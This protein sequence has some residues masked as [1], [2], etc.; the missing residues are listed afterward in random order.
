MTKYRNLVA[1]A[2]AALLLAAAFV[3][4]RKAPATP[5]TPSVS[6]VPLEDQ[7][8]QNFVV[9][10]PGP[11]LDPSTEA[12]LRYIKPGGI[13]LYFRNFSSA[14][15]LQA[16]VSQL[17]RV[18]NETT[19]RPYLIMIDEE[20]GGATRLGLFRNVFAFGEP[21][22]PQI[23]R[24]IA[25][26]Q[27]LGINVELAPL[28]DYPFNADSFIRKRVPAHSVDAMTEFNRKFIVLLKKHGISATLKHFPGMGVFVDDPH[29]TLPQSQVESKVLGDSLKIFHD[30]T[31]AGAE[32]VMTGHG[33]YDSV[34]SGTPATLSHK[35]VTGLLRERLGF[36]GLVITDDLSEMPFITGTNLSLDE[37]T[38]RALQAGHTMVLF[39][40]KL[41]TT[42]QVF[43]R[44]LAR[45]HDDP[46]LRSRIEENYR[47]I[48]AFKAG[49]P[50]MSA[51]APRSA[52]P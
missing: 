48:V 34:D 12:L 11:G 17:Q 36:Q 23:D 24:D 1:I 6:Q 51:S 26:M 7:L 37:A 15:Q 42:A 40:H 29:R 44:V 46:E 45:A 20:P 35:I 10:I 39:S 18:A 14:T 49:H 27:R 32:L 50:A 3:I 5:A 8:G 2:A 13:V 22:W 38:W 41:K 47:R 25:V 33:V 28:A 30:G 52:A 16:L 9:G 31:A 19:H 21:N 43:S 4:L